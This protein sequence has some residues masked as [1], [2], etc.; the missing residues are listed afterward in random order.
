MNWY[1]W[2]TGEKGQINCAIKLWNV[3]I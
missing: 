1:F 3:C 2:S